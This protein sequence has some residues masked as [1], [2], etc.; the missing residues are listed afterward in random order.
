MFFKGR[1]IKSEKGDFF[2]SVVFFE[3]LSYGSIIINKGS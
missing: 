2:G 1:F 3:F